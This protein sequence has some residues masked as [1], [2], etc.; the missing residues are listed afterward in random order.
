MR[1]SN[2]CLQFKSREKKRR[3]SYGYTSDRCAWYGGTVGAGLCILAGT[4]GKMQY[5]LG[6]LA[7]MKSYL[8]VDSSYLNTLLKMLGITYVGQFS[9]GICK[10]AGYSSIAGQIELFARLAVL[11]VSMP[12]LLALLETVHDFL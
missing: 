4:V 8:P 9:A 12:V 10:D 2:N 7:Q 5:L 11:A 6:M 1:T 3:G